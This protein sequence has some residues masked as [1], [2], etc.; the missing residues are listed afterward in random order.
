MSD[1][2]PPPGSSDGSL[3]GDGARPRSDGSQRPDGHRSG[4]TYRVTH[5]TDYRYSTSVS[6]SYSEA[7]LVPRRLP[8]QV[9]VHREIVVRPEPRDYR[10]RYDFFG[11]RAS[12]FSLQEPHRALSVEATSVVN[13]V[14]PAAMPVPVSDPWEQAVHRIRTEVDAEIMTARPYVLVS[15]LIATD[16]LLREY[17]RPSF[18]PGRPLAEAALDLSRRVHEDLT[19]QPGTTTIATSVGEVFERR[20]GVCQD[21]AHLTIACL[22]SLGLPAR[23]VS[24]YLET[25][26][27]SGERKLIGFEA[28]HAWLAVFVPG[29]GWFDLDPTNDCVPDDRYITTAWGRDYA[30]VTPLNGIVFSGGAQEMTVEVTVTRLDL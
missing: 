11:N 22:R 7:H 13:I 14:R 12:F 6:Q 1:P 20:T 9:C 2:T 19:Y 25:A 16:P 28:S 3:P 17:A 30:D 5:R 4:V 10:E 27:P 23:Y 26:P 21:F 18:V 29:A 8:D 24:G 15:P